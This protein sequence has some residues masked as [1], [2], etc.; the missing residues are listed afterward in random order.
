MESKLKLLKNIILFY[1]VRVP[2]MVLKTIP[3]SLVSTNDVIVITIIHI[4]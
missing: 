3:K 2:S 1:V 4:D